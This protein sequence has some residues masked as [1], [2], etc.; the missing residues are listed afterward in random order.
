MAIDDVEHRPASKRVANDPTTPG[1]GPRSYNQPKVLYNVELAWLDTAFTERACRG[2]R[3]I[4]RLIHAEREESM[5]D[6]CKYS[7][8]TL[9]CSPTA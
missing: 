4:L 6:N 7:G 9:R 5:V 3:L 2:K 1:P 8:K